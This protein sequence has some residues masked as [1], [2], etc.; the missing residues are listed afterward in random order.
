MSSD[1]DRAAAFVEGYGRTWQSWDIEGFADLFTEDAVYVV[2][3]TEETVIGREALKF[4]VQKEQQVQGAVTVRMGEP[5]IDQTRVMAE[6]WVTAS[7][8]EETTIVGC[9]VADLEADGRCS[10]FREYW[11]DIEGHVSPYDGWGE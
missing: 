11:F 6:F 5:L 3:P 7:G 2:H 8:V 10:R 9:L 1:R 4:Y